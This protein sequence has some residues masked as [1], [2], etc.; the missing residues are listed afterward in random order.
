MVQ[1][2]LLRNCTKAPTSVRNE[3]QLNLT[4]ARIERGPFEGARSASKKD[5]LA[6]L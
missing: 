5:G 3:G 6:D 1:T 4:I 2:L